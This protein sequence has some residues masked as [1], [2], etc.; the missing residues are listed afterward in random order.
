MISGENQVKNHQVAALLH[1]AALLNT[2]S[3]TSINLDYSN[4]NS[5]DQADQGARRGVQ[6][7]PQLNTHQVQHLRLS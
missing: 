7:S 2:D 5:C 3:S 6:Q 4:S 1:Q